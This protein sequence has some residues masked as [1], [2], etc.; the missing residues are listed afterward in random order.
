MSFRRTIFD[1]AAIS[2]SLLGATLRGTHG[3]S[4]ITFAAFRDQLSNVLT[5]SYRFFTDGVSLFT[6]LY[7]LGDFDIQSFS[8]RICMRPVFFTHF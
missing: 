8:L 5:F 2:F 3:V 7:K 1:S 4:G 6:A